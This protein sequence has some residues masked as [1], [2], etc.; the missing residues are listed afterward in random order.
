MK[1]GKQDLVSALPRW[2]LVFACLLAVAGIWTGAVLSEHRQAG[3]HPLAAWISRVVPQR[4]ILLHAEEYERSWIVAFRLESDLLVRCV[5]MPP[6]GDGH[7]GIQEITSSAYGDKLAT[8]GWTPASM[9]GVVRGARVYAS[10]W[11]INRDF[12][13]SIDWELHFTG[14]PTSLTGKPIPHQWNRSLTVLWE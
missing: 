4:A 13:G 10:T 7:V 14:T 3:L 5:V 8:G 1:E 6:A 9:A 11:R 12:R 2:T